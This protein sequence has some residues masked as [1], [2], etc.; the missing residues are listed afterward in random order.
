MDK[1]LAGRRLLVVDDEM[2]IA[3]MI[4]DMLADMGCEAVSWAAT[5]AQ[6]VALND[7]QDFDAALLDMN[8]NGVY[9]YPVARALDARGV[10]FAF[11]SGNSLR[12]VDEMYQERE[13]LRKPFQIEDLG[14][15]LARLLP[16]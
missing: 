14:K 1:V 11:S 10:P 3:M 13:F 8:L 16:R 5:V 15:V 7:A 4:E 6:A 9:S 12:D 2:L